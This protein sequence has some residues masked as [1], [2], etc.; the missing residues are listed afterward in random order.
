MGCGYHRPMADPRPDEDE[1]ADPEVRRPCWVPL[2]AAVGIFVTG[3]VWTADTASEP[4]TTAT[5]HTGARIIGPYDAQ[6]GCE[7]CHERE[8]QHWQTTKHFRARDTLFDRKTGRATPNAKKYLDIL[9]EKDPMGVSASADPRFSSRCMRCHATTFVRPGRT[10]GLAVWGVSCE[11]CHGPAEHWVHDHSAYRVS[12]RLTADQKRVRERPEDRMARLHDAHTKGM[13]RGDTMYEMAK[14]CYGCH[15]VDDF[16]LIK[17]AGHKPGTASFDYLVKTQGEV[18]HNFLNGPTNRET[19]PARL[20]VMYVVGALAGMDVAAATLRSSPTG[21]DAS[22]FRE[23]LKTTIEELGSR[24]GEAATALGDDAVAADLKESAA[25]LYDMTES[26]GEFGEVEIVG[27]TD[28]VT[29]D[30]R[31]ALGVAIDTFRA[32][33]RALSDRLAGASRT[34]ASLLGALQNTVG[35]KLSAASEAPA[36]EQEGDK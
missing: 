17:H 13:I 24:L 1:Q 32:R 20:R 25:P 33:A 14:Q 27:L 12:G 19:P 9:R 7:K 6:D 30:D 3:L 4:T 31:A 36:T 18:R 23:N 11:S 10:E 16:G 26:E 29:G 35:A 28:A 5:Q 8:L 34:D 21:D 2:S 22:E 15:L